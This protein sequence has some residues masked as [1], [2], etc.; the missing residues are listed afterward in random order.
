M[1]GGFVKK[2]TIFTDLESFMTPE[3]IEKFYQ[4]MQFVDELTSDL[5]GGVLKDEHGCW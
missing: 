2:G 5:F 1:K 3:M 4:R